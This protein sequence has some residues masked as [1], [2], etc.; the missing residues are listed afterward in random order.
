MKTASK[1]K[2]N[3]TIR[4]RSMRHTANNEGIMTQTF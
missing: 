4:N 3:S 2:Y 1:G